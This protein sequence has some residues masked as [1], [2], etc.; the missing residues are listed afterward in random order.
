MTTPSSSTPRFGSSQPWLIGLAGLI[1]G[2]VLGLLVGWVIWPVE[3]TGGTV[4]DLPPA[5]RA[6]YVSA[7][8]DAYVMYSNTDAALEAAR[9][10]EPFGERLP[11]EV[12]GALDYFQVEDPTNA[13]RV[14][15]IARLAGALGVPI[16]ATDLLVP[17]PAPPQVSGGVPAA[18]PAAAESVPPAT[19]DTGSGVGRWLLITL[20]ALLLIGVGVG[21][22]YYIARRRDPTWTAGSAGSGDS[23][24]QPLPPTAVSAAVPRA[25][26]VTPAAAAG[27]STWTPATATAR[28]RPAPAD[29]DEDDLSFDEED[30][31][32]EGAA[33][34]HGRLPDD[35]DLPWAVAAD[36]AALDEEADETRRDQ[37]AFQG[38]PPQGYAD[39][40]EEAAEADVESPLGPHEAI[41]DEP[42]A[43]EDAQTK[44][45]F[46]EAGFGAAQPAPPPTPLA[47]GA[48]AGA[49]AGA[50]ARAAA[51]EPRR[52]LARFSVTYQAGIPDYAETYNIV[53]PDTARYLG[54]C[55]MGVSDQNKALRSDED[56]VVALDVYLFDKYDE[57]RMDTRTQILLS[58]YGAER[59]FADAFKQRQDLS[60]APLTPQAGTVFTVMGP[61][62]LMQAEVVEAAYTND[63]VFQKVR[64][65]LIVSTR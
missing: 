63:G 36:V 38:S 44:G 24:S 53:D 27:V 11:D 39:S 59:D 45:P 29:Y 41:G 49:A 3:W 10:L 15:N 7:V 30:E 2:L 54:E 48:L 34:V 14:G 52:S 64:L 43:D 42:D 40:F 37:A 18:Q 32:D 62:L 51:P 8:A 22:I 58:R 5:Q 61:K 1:A 25:A 17:T 50:A 26:P 9:R 57:Q 28:T 47:A 19:A 20:G 23:G 35:D 13:V 21:L 60:A 56:A 55:G 12:L 6:N 65:N 31:E 4:A 33:V 16:D 46:A